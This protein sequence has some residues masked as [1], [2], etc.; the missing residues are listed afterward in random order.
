MDIHIIQQLVKQGT[1]EFSVHAQQER[2][3]EDLD[4][5]EIEEAIIQ[6]EI[7]EQY[8]DDPRGES[9]LV[10]VVLGRNNPSPYTV[11]GRPLYVHLNGLAIVLLK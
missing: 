4:V 7:L 2:L 1:Y 10:L 5:T 11:N 9:C 3:E 8:P 6:G